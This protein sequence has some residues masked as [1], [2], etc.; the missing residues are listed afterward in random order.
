MYWAVVYFGQ[1][2]LI[3]EEVVQIFGLLFQGT[4]KLPNNKF[5]KNGLEYILSYFEQTHLITLELDQ[6]SLDQKSL[7]KTLLDEMNVIRQNIVRQ[8]VI[9]QNIVRQNVV[10]QNVIR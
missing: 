10:R 9:R 5:D 7:D 1:F 6:M 2:F 8:N 4:Y 3:G